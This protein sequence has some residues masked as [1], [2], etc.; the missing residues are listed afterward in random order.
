MTFKKKSLFLI[1][2]LA[3]SFFAFGLAF[4]YYKWWPYHFLRQVVPVQLKNFSSKAGEEALF[5]ELFVDELAVSNVLVPETASRQQLIDQVNQMQA[6]RLD[7]RGLGQ[8]IVPA[9]SFGSLHPLGGGEG[10][11]V[12]LSYAVDGARFDAYSYRVKAHDAI[13]AVL[14]IPGSGLNQSSRIV[15]EDRTNYHYG[16]LAPYELCDQYVLIKPNED[17]LAIHRRGRKLTEL[18]YINHLYGRGSS[19]SSRY[20][21]DAIALSLAL[22][23][24]YQTQIVT[25]LSQGA[26]AAMLVAIESK[27]DVCISASGYT[28][29]SSELA[30]GGYNSSLVFPG[31]QQAILGERL[32]PALKSTST[33]FLFLSGRNE[34]GVT[35]YDVSGNRTCQRFVGL[36]NVACEVHDLGHVYPVR[37][38]EN[39]LSR[40]FP[41]LGVQPRAQPN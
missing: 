31:L 23:L 24:H 27:P 2:L 41:D 37:E 1:A 25:G 40:L 20:I 22:K 34:P 10:E 33:Q 35:A 9:V 38:V 5:D 17:Y 13:C 3:A 36:S 14:V 18:A 26:L 21:T 15:M 8:A 7:I 19:Y 30:Y 29:L 32:I 6:P 16:V 11:V 12:R 28:E 39:Y 4:A